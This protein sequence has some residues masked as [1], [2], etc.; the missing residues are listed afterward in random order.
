VIVL[1]IDDLLHGPARAEAKS[2]QLDL[3]DGHAVDEQEDVVAVVAVARVDAELVDDLEGVFAPVLEIDQSIVQRRAIIAGEAVALAQ[4]AGRGEDIGGDDLVKEARELAVREVDAVEGLELFAEVLLQRRAAADV[5][6][7]FVFETA[8][9]FDESQL[10]ILL[11]HDGRHGIV[12]G[13]IDCFIGHEIQRSKN[14]VPVILA[15]AFRVATQ[16]GW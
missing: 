5:G 14:Y 15:E 2:L 4:G 12:Y 1:V 7:D 11:P 9:L 10:D 3:D 16:A 8:Q 6:A 13:E